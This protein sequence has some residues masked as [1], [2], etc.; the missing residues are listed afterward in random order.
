MNLY[1]V[2]GFDKPSA[3]EYA[4]IPPDKIKQAYHSSLLA[5]HPDKQL[6]SPTTP[7]NAS[8]LIPALKSAYAVLSDPAQR[9]A[10]DKTLSRP[11]SLSSAPRSA[12]AVIDLAAMHCDE[13]DPDQIKWTRPCRC[14]DAGGY[15][16]TETDL[17]ANGS[18]RAIMVQC[19]GC[20]LWI[21]VVYDV[22]EP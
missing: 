9:S 3:Q 22:E 10:Y 5:H 1:Q 16:L 19:A 6:S 4:E 18:A 20:S 2:L 14:G 8:H 15:V 7:A 21:E 12:G 17:E 11:G 13:T